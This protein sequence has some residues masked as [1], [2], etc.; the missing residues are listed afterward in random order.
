MKR[1]IFPAVYLEALSLLSESENEFIERTG[2]I[3]NENNR[4]YRSVSKCY[5]R[6][7]LQGNSVI[8]GICF[9]NGNNLTYTVKAASGNSVFF[10]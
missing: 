9:A 10:T 8:Y 5:L 1:E 6:L 2:L 4:D 7:L 3:M